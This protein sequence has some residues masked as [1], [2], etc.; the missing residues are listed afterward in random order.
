VPLDPAYPPERLMYMVTDGSVEWLLTAGEAVGQLLG[1]AEAQIVKLDRDREAIDLE[2]STS[3]R[4]AVDPDNL[5]YIIYTSGSTGRPK[6]VA[7][8]HA[9]L[10]NLI[11]WDGTTLRPQSRMLQFSSLNFDAS[12]H[13]LFATWASGGVIV[14]ITREQQLDPRLLSREIRDN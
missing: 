1:G 9:A 12:F 8:S 13:E 3:P 5:I 10:A 14:L 2:A 11:Y 4:V 7:L 6:G